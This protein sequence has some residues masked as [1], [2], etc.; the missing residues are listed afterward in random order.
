MV[1][2]VAW[3]DGGGGMAVWVDGGRREAE[4]REMGGARRRG[5]VTN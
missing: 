5:I 2:V 4:E 1:A 3:R